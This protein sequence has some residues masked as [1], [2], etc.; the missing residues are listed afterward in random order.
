MK[1]SATDHPSSLSFLPSFL[2]S[3]PFPII[4]SLFLNLITTTISVIPVNATLRI[5]I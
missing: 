3:L 5:Y 4:P 2:P 1:E